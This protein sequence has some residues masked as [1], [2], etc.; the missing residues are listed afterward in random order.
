VQ[1]QK[2]LTGVE[3]PAEMLAQP[4]GDVLDLDL[5]HQV[6]GELGPQFGQRGGQDL[7]ALVGGLM[8][9]EFIGQFG[10][11]ELGQCR[12]VAGGLVG[13]PAADHDRVQIDI[14]ACGDQC[15]V[16]AGHHHQFVDELVVGTA[17]AAN[18]LAQHTFL[19]L[20]HRLHHQHLEVEV[21]LPDVRPLLDRA[22][23]GREG[24]LLVVPGMLDITGAVGLGGQRPVDPGHRMGELV[25]AA[26][27]EQPL[28][29]GELRRPGVSPIRFQRSEPGQQITADANVLLF[30]PACRGRPRQ[31][32]GG[33]L[34]PAPRVTAQLPDT[35]VRTRILRH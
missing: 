1:L 16:A 2:T 13:E 32:I 11:H 34:Q 29:L 22:R 27:G 14:E 25:V 5:G 18:F 19:R 28:H 30:Q 3:H 12:Q 24:V 4:A 21:I 33:L 6:Q 35:V 10:V 20:G 8:V 7:R 15:L 23:V 17:P 31:P 9:G 26:R